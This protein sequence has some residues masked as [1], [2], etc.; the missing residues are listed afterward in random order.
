MA[1]PSRISNE[2]S[3]T[4]YAIAHKTSSF[5][6]FLYRNGLNFAPDVFCAMGRG[7][8]ASGV[9]IMSYS[10]K[11]QSTTFGAPFV[12]AGGLIITLLGMASLYAGNQVAEVQGYVKASQ[13]A[14]QQH[15]QSG[16]YGAA[17]KI[18]RNSYEDLL[19][20]GLSQDARNFSQTVKRLEEKLLAFGSSRLLFD[21]NYQPRV[22]LLQLLKIV[23]MEPLNKSEKAIV[24]INNWAQKN[25]L[26]HGERW[27]EQTDRFEELKPKIKPLL[28]ELGFVDDSSPHFKEYQGAIVHGA[29]LPRVRLRLQYLIEQWKQ[30]VRFSHIYFLSGERPLEAQH[31]NQ[32]T[33]MDDSGSLLKIRKEW[34][35]PL[36]FPKT[37]SEMT[38]LIWEQSEIPEDMRK[39][40]EVHFINAPMKKD[41]KSDRLI[42][43]TT[44]DTVETWFKAL[45]PHGRY[46]AITNAPYTNRQDLV[47]RAI[48][49]K[50][51]GFDTVGSG[52]KGQE[53]TAIFLDE[54]ARFI[55]QIK[56]LSEK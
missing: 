38:Q 4:P 31:E 51:Y 43:P 13:N 42:R 41:S 32:S 35:V 17:L 7:L 27:H 48:A 22:K 47:V 1:T 12:F 28:N 45:P 26:R 34:S 9:G 3:Q 15:E 44:D 49:P 20:M 29:L 21:E 46:L 23:G 19:K 54:L 37:E 8:S 10:R 25:L 56:Q 39:E 14:I 11:L 6:D 50:G 16:D 30:G 36:E 24:Q 33:F 2:Y 5:K 40:V 53:K 18:A 55:F 52:S